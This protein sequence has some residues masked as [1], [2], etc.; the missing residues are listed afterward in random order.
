VGAQILLNTSHWE[1][2]RPIVSSASSIIHTKQQGS[3]V[4][5][6]QGNLLELMVTATALVM[7]D[8]MQLQFGGLV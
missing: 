1:V 2:V 3:V 7:E 5:V 8:S 6:P 4:I